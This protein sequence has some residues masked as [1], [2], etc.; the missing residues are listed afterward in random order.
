MPNV[1]G[2]QVLDEMQSD[3]ELADVPVILLTATSYADDALTQFGSQIVIHRSGGL[4][5]AETLRCL[6][7]V[8]NVLEP[9]YNDYVPT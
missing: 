3:P 9:S 8:V 4:P 7:A 2:F 6:D 1:D 5:A